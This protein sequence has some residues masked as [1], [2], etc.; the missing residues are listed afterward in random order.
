[1]P[2]LDQTIELVRR[3][4]TACSH[5]AYGLLQILVL[6]DVERKTDVLFRALD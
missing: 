3:V 1:M 4:R 6:Q 2:M 5:S